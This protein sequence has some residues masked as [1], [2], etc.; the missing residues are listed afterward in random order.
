ME[1]PRAAVE[2]RVHPI[3][4]LRA[5]V[6]QLAEPS[7][8]PLVDRR[9]C[10]IVRWFYHKVK[11]G[12]VRVF[13]PSRPVPLLRANLRRPRPPQARLPIAPRP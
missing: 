8:K 9:G 7:W 12:G 3:T 13:L 6:H 10:A 5:A 1:L 2:P 11:F 4:M